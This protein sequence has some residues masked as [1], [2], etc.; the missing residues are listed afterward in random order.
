MN[1]I[2]IAVEKLP[3]NTPTEVD[4]EKFYGALHHNGREVGF[5]TREKFDHDEFSLRA[6]NAFTNGNGWDYYD[7][8][9]LSDLINDLIGNKWSVYEFDS[10]VELMTWVLKNDSKSQH[11]E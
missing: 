11:L 4:V 10:F 1:K 2:Q 8:K 5:V 7:N 9:S 6:T 3:E